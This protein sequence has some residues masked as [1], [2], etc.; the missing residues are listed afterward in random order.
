LEILAISTKQNR[1]TLRSTN[2]ETHFIFKEHKASNGLIE[3]KYYDEIEARK[4]SK[5]EAQKPLLLTRE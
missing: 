1:I 4:V 2:G 5:L 3:D